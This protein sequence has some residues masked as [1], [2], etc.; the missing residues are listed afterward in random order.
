MS[1]NARV[2]KGASAKNLQTARFETTRFGKSRIRSESCTTKTPRISR[3]PEFCPE[4]CSEISPR[5]FR[6]SFPCN[7]RPQ[8]L[9]QNPH[10]FSTPNPQ[11]S[12]KKIFAKGF[13]RKKLPPPPRLARKSTKGVQKTTP[14]ASLKSFSPLSSLTLQ[15]LLFRKKSKGNPEKNARVSLFAEP[16]K[17]LE[18]KGKTQKKTREIGKQKKQGNRKQQGLEG[19]SLAA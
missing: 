2:Q 7:G 15:P 9:H 16:L 18:K 11:A 12:S 3:I 5:I 4:F 8:K 13:R 14:E 19:P 10:H 1:A 17:S 6:A